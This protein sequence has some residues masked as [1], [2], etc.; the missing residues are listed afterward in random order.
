MCN[1]ILSKLNQEFWTWKNL[2]IIHL[3]FP[4]DV[5]VGCE[6]GDKAAG[7][8]LAACLVQEN[9]PL[10]CATCGV[11]LGFPT[12]TTL[13]S[14]S[15]ST[16]TSTCGPS[17][18]GTTPGGSSNEINHIDENNGADDVTEQTLSSDAK[19][20]HSNMFKAFLKLIIL[21]IVVVIELNR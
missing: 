2:E 9:L 20:I 1:K 13:S 14:T 16:S 12:P 21:C 15:T 8:S 10:C 6:Y 4:C 18:T 7:C 11:S 5:S 19:C 3:V 17:T